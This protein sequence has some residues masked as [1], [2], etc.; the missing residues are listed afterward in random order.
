MDDIVDLLKIKIEKAKAALPTATVN[1]IA[2]VDLR[3]AILGLRNK[4]G[5]SFEQ[6][7]DL[8]LE[9]ELLLC[10]LVNPENYPE[11]L[12]KRMQISKAAI[13]E[14]VNEMNNLVFKKIREELVKNT[15]RKKIFAKRKEE[16]AKDT[17]VLNSV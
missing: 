6:L 13:N 16:D 12:S 17:E 11:E 10:G 14:L 2:A 9:T 15:E 7:G 5:Y 1:A 3:A 8:E 4:Y